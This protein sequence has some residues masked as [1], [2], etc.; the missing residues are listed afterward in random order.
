MVYLLW[1]KA[2]ATYT[3]YD[4]KI[5]NLQQPLNRPPHPQHIFHTSL[6][7]F[8]LVEEQLPDARNSIEVA[9]MKMQ[10]NDEG[11]IAYVSV[12][13]AALDCHV[14]NRGGGRYTILPFTDIDPRSFIKAHDGWFTIHLIY[15]IAAHQNRLMLSPEGDVQVLPLANH[16]QISYDFGEAFT[17]QFHASVHANVEA[18]YSRAGLNASSWLDEMTQWTPAEAARYALEARENIKRPL[19]GATGITQCAFYDPIEQC[20]RFANM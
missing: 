5:M 20:W 17:T 6:R 14:R 7:L 9:C 16:F 18:L 19:T 11:M 13:D 12:M 2:G 8:T 1:R 3:I 10:G 15:G 4:W